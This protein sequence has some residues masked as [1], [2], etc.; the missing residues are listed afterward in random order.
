MKRLVM[1]GYAAFLTA[2][3]FLI[4]GFTMLVSAEVL[5]DVKNIEKIQGSFSHEYIQKIN[6]EYVIDLTQLPVVAIKQS[7]NFLLI[8]SHKD[9]GAEKEAVFSALKDFD[10][11]LKKISYADVRF[12]SGIFQMEGNANIGPYSVREVEGKFYMYVPT[13]KVSHFLFGIGTATRPTT[14]TSRATTTT[15]EP[16]TTTSQ[17][18]T[19]TTEPTT[20][21]S[22][23][24]TTTTEPTT[25]TSQ[26]T[27]TT[28]I[29]DEE[30]DDPTIPLAGPTTTQ[31]EWEEIEDPTIPLEGPKTGDAG[32][33]WKM[34]GLFLIS[35]AAAM[36]AL[37]CAK[38]KKQR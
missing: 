35:G 24:T 4:A 37:G 26:A 5:P 3:V 7:S 25:T 36:T 18:T 32:A 10:S 38:N 22:Q 23:A 30:I 28:T 14:T 8:W 17:A 19:T 11:S 16:T 12:E 33:P 21:T 20:T 27:T 6:G 29:E 1:R 15:T 13:S 9:L 34:L 31:E 2:A